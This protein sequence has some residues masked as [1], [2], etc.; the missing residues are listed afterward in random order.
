[1]TDYAGEQEMELEALEA[2]LMDDLSEYEGMLP[3]GWT[4][5]GQTYKVR[6]VAQP[7][8]VAA[9]APG[10][11]RDGRRVGKGTFGAGVQHGGWGSSLGGC[12]VLSVVESYRQQEVMESK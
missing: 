12:R 3:P 6:S 8:A 9:A 10:F 5:H 1:M 2:I 7:A 11:R 4:T